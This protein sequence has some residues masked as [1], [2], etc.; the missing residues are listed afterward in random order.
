MQREPLLRTRSMVF[1]R[2]ELCPSP[3][4]CR[5]QNLYSTIFY[6]LLSDLEYFRTSRVG[7]YLPAVETGTLRS[8]S[9]ESETQPPHPRAI[10]QPQNPF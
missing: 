2:R 5:K 4:K 6:S 9:T 7:G 10:E 1:P 3:T 8:A